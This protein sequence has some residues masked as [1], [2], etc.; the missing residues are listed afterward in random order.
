MKRALLAAVLLVAFVATLL[1][2]LPVGRVV[3]WTLAEAGVDPET[4]VFER[5]HLAWNGILLEDVTLETGAG[6][7]LALPWLRVRPSLTG[8]LTRGDGLPATAAGRLC[9]GWL[10]GDLDP[11][12]GGHRIAGVWTDVDLARCADGLGIPGDLS[13]TIQGRIDLTV[14]AHGERHG[15]GVARL[16]DAEWHMP[17]VPRHVPTRAD[18][19]ELQWD[20]DGRIATVRRFELH[21]DELD[22]T[23]TGTITLAEPIVDS[24]LALDLV[25]RPRAAMPQAHRDVLRS[26]PGGPPD[27]RGARRFALRGTVGTPILERPS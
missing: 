2:S 11:A 7:G 17:G 14:G 3:R 24:R 1:A 13:G 18:A 10:D 15:T 8:L 6:R 4:L 22:A 26:L 16:R 9:G 27:A 25:V 19:A 20:V 21:N 23:A 12:D 5:A